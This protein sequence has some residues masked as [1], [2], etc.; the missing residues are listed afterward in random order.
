M[1]TF[2]EAMQAL[3]IEELR[4]T[5]EAPIKAIRERVDT[6]VIMPTGSGKSLIYQLPAVMWEPWLTVVISPLKA[7]QADQVEALRKKGISAALLNSSLTTDEREQVL[8]DIR[9]GAFALLYIAPEQLK[10]QAVRDV[11]EKIDIAHVVVDEAHIL[12]RDK[13]SFRQAYNLIAEFVD[14]LKERP[15]VAA[16]TATATQHDRK[17]IV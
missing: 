9:A 5:Q 1:K 3:G 8:R 12:A 10:N 15:V 6:L 17:V 13:D 7:L 16:F 4:K 2:N 11:L 14:E